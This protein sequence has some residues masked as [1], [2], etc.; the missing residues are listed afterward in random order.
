MP[1]RDPWAYI[2]LA[3]F[4]ALLFVALFGDRIAP[5]E[6]IFFVPE[7]GRDPRP[8][9]P[10]LVFPLGSDVLGRDLLSVV[11]AGARTTLAIVLVGGAAR[12]A[13]GLL[14]ASLAALWRPARV[15]VDALS[16]LVAAVP[17]TL[18]VLLVVLVFVRG[19]TT[20]LVF[21]AALL[22][23]G[24]AGP[25][26]IARLELDRLAHTQ[27][28][29]AAMSVGARR[30]RILAR[31]HLPHLVPPLAV[32]LS[33]QIVASLVALAE[34][35]VLGVFV[36]SVRSINIEE[37]LTFVRVGQTNR[38]LISDPP[39]WGGLL[40]N[41][42]T[43]ENLWTTRWVFLV[44]GIAFALAAVVVG[45]I[46]VALAR[47]YARRD[48]FVDLRGRGARI[49]ALCVVLLVAVTMLLPERYA[50]ARSWATDARG[51]LT[52][53]AD[54][55]AAFHDAGLA[56][57]D[58]S[59]VAEREVSLLRQTAPANVEVG[60][61]KVSE[62]SEGPLEVLAL[63]FDRSGGGKVTAPL[64]FA[65]WGLSPADYP[66]AAGSIFGPLDL[67]TALADWP[68]DYAQIDVRGRVVVLLRPVG[69]VGGGNRLIS[70]PDQAS[71]IVNAM[72]RGAV[73]VVLVDPTLPAMPR[74]SSASRANIYER[75]AAESPIATIDAPPVVVLGLPAADRLLAPVGMRPSTVYAGLEGM[76]ISTGSEYAK[77]SAARALGVSATVDVPIAPASAHP[78]SILGEV[79]G[80]AVAG[81]IVVWGVTR[82]TDA[83]SADV[84][85]VLATLARELAARR[86]PFVF[87]AFDPTVDEAGN[88]AQLRARL[89]DERIALIVVLDKIRGDRF[90]LTTAM[91]QYVPALDLYAD[92]AGA[93]HEVTRTTVAQSDTSGVVWP[94]IRPFADVP[95]VVVNGAGPDGDLRS[96]IAS[97][98]GYMAGRIAVGAEEAPR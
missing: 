48:I 17:A 71:L 56:P 40:A 81:R 98:L 65:G 53:T 55:E 67:G 88:A 74:I 54:L 6:A 9:D 14:A 27:F 52:H 10:G 46:G 7:H 93:R 63:L 60:D 82:G 24:W 87:V 91:G 83:S 64:V 57:V 68:D 25:Y 22:I 33:Q 97:W 77:R 42:R 1:R 28:T 59:F 47:R 4:F 75:L 39:E 90:K 79:G 66:P 11:L 20:P 92:K 94:G 36:G 86:S 2:G 38:A 16:E 58:G 12:V 80:A 26:R 84:R 19:D 72:K 51:A 76:Y 8:Y 5:H 73:A 37:S 23:T 45:L 85:D 13:L 95:S 78:R 31:H 21:V 29:D 44:P 96:D 49:L 69:L 89:G 32:N 15:A 70:G 61:A 62:S 30:A 35:G 34:L 50:E 43:T 3:A 41:A 18:I